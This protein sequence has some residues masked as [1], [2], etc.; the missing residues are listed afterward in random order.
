MN[1][2]DVRNTINASA[3]AIDYNP[4]DQSILNKVHADKFIMTLTLP[5]AMREINVSQ[6]RAN[7]TIM[8]NSLQ[9]SVAGVV[10]PSIV[11]DPVE[12]PFS[13]QSFNFTSFKRPDY[14]NVSVTF[15][16]DN[17]YN[18]Y[19]VIYKWISLL[20]N[21]KEGFFYAERPGLRHGPGNKPYEEYATDVT[22]FGLDEYN[23]KKIQFTYVGCVPVSL[24]EISY[25]YKDSSEI[26]SS[27][28]FA[29][30]QLHTKLL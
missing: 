28:E 23:E 26:A 4:M 2:D 17:Q 25:D 30:S 5:K 24:G 7:D 1:V 20:N 12:V 27:F 9:F 13:G 11:V 14:S 21:A 6:Q 8:Q 18:N 3:S 29:F 19:W 15:K 22:I 10:V 16:I